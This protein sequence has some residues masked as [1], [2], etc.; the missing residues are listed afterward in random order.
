MYKKILIRYGEL[1]L[2]KKNRKQFINILKDNLQMQL[3]FQLN[4]GFDRIF[5]DYSKESLEKLKYVF[6]ISSYSPVIVCDPNLDEL[7]KV[8]LDLINSKNNIFTFKVSTHRNDKKFALNSNQIN[9]EIGG[10]VLSHKDWKVKLKNPDL[11]INIEIR[12]DNIYI[13]IDSIAGLGGL[14][15]GSSGKVLHLLSGG[16]DSPVA[17]FKLIKRGLRVDFLSFITPPQTDN[18][19]VE[20]MKK[21]VEILNKYQQKAFFYLINY[22][23]LMNY[24]GLVS[25]QSYK[26]TLMRRSFYRIAQE[27]AK[28]YNYLALSNGDN[29]GQVASQTLESINVISDVSELPIF[30]PLLTNDKIETINIANEI[31]TYPISIIKAN[32]TCEL[33]APKQPVIKPTIEIAQSLEKELSMISELENKLLENNIETFKIN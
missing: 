24:I 6:G 13:F 2:K 26:I 14:P 29:I 17:A 28:K 5:I 9:N 12:K 25:N 23:E 19:T 1:V 30:R 21:F 18:T 11:T 7:K 33:F 27:I 3:G 31:G 10:F 16:I 20:K 4:A 32:E 15:V 22:T 8:I